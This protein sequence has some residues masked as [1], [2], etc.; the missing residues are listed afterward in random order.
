MVDYMDNW[1]IETGTSITGLHHTDINMDDKFRYTYPRRHGGFGFATI[2]NQMYGAYVGSILEAL[3]PAGLDI[4]GDAIKTDYGLREMCNYV[5]RTL[6]HIPSNTRIAGEKT[7]EGFYKALAPFD[8]DEVNLQQLQ[9]NTGN[10]EYKKLFIQK[11]NSSGTNK[12]LPR[13]M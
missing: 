4:K 11:P 8:W 5:K 10:P 7:I 1:M 12:G 13:R 6:P 9:T 2:A 3:Y